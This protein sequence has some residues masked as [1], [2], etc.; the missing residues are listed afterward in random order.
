[1]DEVTEI[2][3]RVLV[4]K[5]GKIIADD[6]P[7]KLADSIASARVHLMISSGLSSLVQ[8]MQETA[9]LYTVH[10]HEV[11]VEVPEDQIAPFLIDLAEKKIAYSH[12]SID[13]PTLEDYFLSVAK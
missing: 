1:M 5:N 11:V 9:R 8:Y 4:L 2:C 6:T 7:Q 10:D 12:I 3:D 13:K